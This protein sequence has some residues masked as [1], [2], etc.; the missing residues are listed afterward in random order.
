MTPYQ[1][2]KITIATQRAEAERIAKLKAQ[3]KRIK[4]AKPTSE[5]KAESAPTETKPTAEQ[6][7]DKRKTAKTVQQWIGE[8]RANRK[9]EI[10]FLLEKLGI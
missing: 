2:K 10:E 8:R 3:P 5:T 1:K 9:K 4:I 6:K 7:F